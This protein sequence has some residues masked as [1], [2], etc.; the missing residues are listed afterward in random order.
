MPPR[1]PTP[2]LVLVVFL[3]AAS[4]RAQ[5]APPDTLPPQT[6]AI[7]VRTLRAVYEIDAQPFVA[8]M[9]VVNESAYP[10]YL[11][12]G[13]VVGA[14]ALASGADLDPAVRLA[15]AEGGAVALTFAVKRL[16]RRPRPYAALDGVAAR[17]RGHIGDDIFDPYSFPSGHTSMAFSVATS[18]SLSYPE[19]YVAAPALAWA[20]A[21]GLARVWHGVHYPSD[22]LV[23][24][25]VGAGAAFLAHLLTPGLSDA[26]GEGGAVAPLVIVVPL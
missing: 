26:D 1:P 3:A 17:D 13:P 16:V 2:W 15:V 8:T 19:W 22:V 20:S 12:A 21:M 9:R 25:G 7:D 6:E 11:G 5:E 24:A 10:V 23:G 18:L 14:V 4:P